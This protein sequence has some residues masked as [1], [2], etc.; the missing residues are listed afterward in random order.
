MDMEKLTNE[1]WL[2]LYKAKW[3]DKKGKNREWIFASRRDP[4]LVIRERSA[5][6]VVIIP[7]LQKEGEPD[8]LVV[9]K[10]WRATIDGYEHGFP[11]GIIEDNE[12]SIDAAKRELLEETGLTLT[13]IHTIS[14]PCFVGTSGGPGMAC[15][16]FVYCK[17]EISNKNQAEDE[18]IETFALSLE[19]LGNLISSDIYF[20]SRTWLVI[21][22]MLKHRKIS[23][24]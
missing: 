2:N 7:I 3:I 4:A 5:G 23:F 1:K 17:G 22:N 14:P 18:D 21:N 10:E 19:E 24:E 11:A 13:K 15:Y 16:A 6:A 9:T 20:G 12:S 8:K